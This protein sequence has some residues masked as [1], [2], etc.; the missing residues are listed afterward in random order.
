MIRIENVEVFGLETAIRGMR[1]PMDSWDRSDSVWCYKNDRNKSKC[2]ELWCE[3][4]V[5]PFYEVGENDLS[6]M[7]KLAKAG[8]V[9]GKYLRMINVTCDITAPLYWWKEFDTY[10]V[11]TVANSCSTMHKIQEKEFILDDFSHDHM[12]SYSPIILEDTIKALNELREFYLNWD[13]TNY[14]T[15][16]VN[17]LMYFKIHCTII[18]FNI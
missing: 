12:T 3:D 18:Y 14:A 10:K 13:S 4:C 6:L 17:E 8:S 9:H 2:H 7:R 1:N 16:K 15:R 5:K 11:G